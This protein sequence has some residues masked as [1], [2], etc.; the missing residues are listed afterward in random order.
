MRI[1]RTQHPLVPVSLWVLYRYSV[2]NQIVENLFEHQPADVDQVFKVEG[3]KIMATA[4]FFGV[5]ELRALR[6]DLAPLSRSR[7][8]E[9]S[10]WAAWLIEKLGAAA[11][12]QL[13]LEISRREH[14]SPCLYRICGENPPWRPSHRG[15]RFRNLPTRT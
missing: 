2:L 10:T 12:E 14:A 1:E 6:P 11:V 15:T 7:P 3:L 4:I 5:P 9:I 13:S 8:E